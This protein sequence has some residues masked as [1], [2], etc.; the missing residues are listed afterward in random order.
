M[1]EGGGRTGPPLLQQGL[2]GLEGR[3]EAAAWHPRLCGDRNKLSVSS[4]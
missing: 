1:W 2:G 3:E 4:E